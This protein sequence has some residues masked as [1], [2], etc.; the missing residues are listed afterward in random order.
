MAGAYPPKTPP[1]V[2]ESFMPRVPSIDPKR[3]NEIARL[4]KLLV[5]LERI[6]APRRADE[7][8][9]EREATIRAMLKD[10]GATATK[11]WA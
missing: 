10:L 5:Q 3:D 6:P 2:P 4:H 8:A 11:P 1:Q 7:C 9:D